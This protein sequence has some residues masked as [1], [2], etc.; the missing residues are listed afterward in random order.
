MSLT[1]DLDPVLT[2]ELR[3]QIVELWAEVTNAGGAV[4]F[5]PPVVA[6]DVRPTAAAAFAGVE[7]GVDRL[8]IGTEDGRLVALLFISG[9]R[10]RLKGHWRVLS[11][12]MVTPAGQGRGYGAALMR[13]AATIARSMG[14]TGLQVLVRSGT[15]T[16]DF[17]AK[18][19]YTE[20]GRLPGA[21]RVAEGDDRDE[22]S[23]WLPLD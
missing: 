22:I 10:H 12:V 19:G 9:S 1:F 17:Y 2:G 21:L 3:E 11:R 13:E 18:L 8:L 6:D 4:G 5:V 20:V 7:S 15:G 23:M 14:L 16:E